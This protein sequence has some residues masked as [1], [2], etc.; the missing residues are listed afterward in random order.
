MYMTIIDKDTED[1]T[2]GVAFG[3]QE[4]AASNVNIQKGCE[5]SCLYCYGQSMSVKFGRTKGNAWTSPVI[6]PDKVARG[7]CKRRGTVMFP[8]SHDIT[9]ANL[10][11]CL[12]VLKKMLAAGNDV[13]VVSK[14]HLE[15]VKRLCRELEAYK[16]QI[17]F[18]FTIGSADDAVLAFWEP[19]APTYGERLACLRWAFRHG[20]K[21][22]VSCEPMLD[23]NIQQV[24][25][26]TRSFVTD[27]IWL[28]RV[29]NLRSALCRNAPG[30]QAASAKADELLA[31]QTNKWVKALYE[32]HKHDPLIKYKDSI[33]KIVGLDRP[34]EKGLDI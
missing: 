27:S 26:D 2:P 19:H 21:T 31:L 15:C 25:D 1:K 8:S 33:K 10:D 34:E 28:G 9:T 16:D 17:L 3:T 7:Y 11:S 30:N 6:N 23:D 32:T 5:H 12:A 20:Y 4:W 24:I 18:R 13:L 22:S 29:N 14:P